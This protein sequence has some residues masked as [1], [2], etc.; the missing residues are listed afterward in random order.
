M[1][2]EKTYLNVLFFFFSV[3]VCKYILAYRMLFLNQKNDASRKKTYLNAFFFSSQFLSFFF[4]SFYYAAKIESAKT[5]KHNEPGDFSG[6]QI[7]YFLKVQSDF[8]FD[9]FHA[10]V[11][12]FV[13]EKKNSNNNITIT[14]MIMC[15]LWPT[16]GGRGSLPF[17]ASQKPTETIRK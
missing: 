7:M 6:F 13:L 12:L 16:G 14:K 3:N 1:T 2:T 15:Q 17:P 4:V 8:T 5:K 11:F 10:I 9:R